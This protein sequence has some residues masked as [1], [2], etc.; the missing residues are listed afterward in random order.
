VLLLFAFTSL[1]RVNWR[2][3]S[4]ISILPNIGLSSLYSHIEYITHTHIYRN[5]TNK[6]IWFSQHNH[7]FPLFV[8]L[9]MKKHTYRTHLRFDHQLPLRNILFNQNRIDIELEFSNCQLD[10]TYNDDESWIGNIQY[11]NLSSSFVASLGDV[12]SEICAGID[13]VQQRTVRR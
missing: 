1:D 13:A 12:I 8:Y 10:D 5:D 9:S 3:I 4:Y 11:H 6:C 2:W 7:L